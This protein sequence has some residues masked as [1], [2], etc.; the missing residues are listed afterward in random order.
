MKKS[1]ADNPSDQLRGMYS[2]LLAAY[3]PRK[4]WPANSPFEVI[5]GAYL[6]QATA[7]RNVEQSIANLRASGILSIAGI[8]ATA[9]ESLRDTIRPSGFALRKAA[10]IKA[11]VQ[12]LDE[13]YS[14][15]LEQ[16]AAQPVD[17]LRSQLLALPGVGPET[18][19]A[20]L[21]YAFEKPVF[22]VDE[23]FRRVATRHELVPGNARYA[24][25]QSLGNLTV[26]NPSSEETT[27]HANELHALIVEV[28]KQHC[29]TVPRC[30]DCP[31]APLLPGGRF[32]K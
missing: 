23:Y 31:L 19:D 13:H 16:I 15:S 17:L 28:G 1:S 25:L 2:A 3:G 8:R 21:L 4:W 11:F 7:W 24:E 20:I 9:E 14:G 6:T 10:S 29:G 12:F 32:A 26:A 27:R 30:E 18:A 22:V 5:L